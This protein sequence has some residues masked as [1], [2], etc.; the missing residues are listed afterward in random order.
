MAASVE[1]ATDL[2]DIFSAPKQNQVSAYSRD[3]RID[4]EVGTRAVH[5]WISG[6]AQEFTPDILH[7]SNCARWVVARIVSG[8][9]IQVRFN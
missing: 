2:N 4:A 1:Y 5:V 6:D 8:Y 9:F 7:K 3:P